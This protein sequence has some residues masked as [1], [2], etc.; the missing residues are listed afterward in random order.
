M[1]FSPRVPLRS[2]WE[3][4]CE[5]HISFCSARYRHLALVCFRL[6]GDSQSAKGAFLR[7]DNVVEQP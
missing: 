2:K 6:Y 4:E 7:K 1:G 5:A 3:S